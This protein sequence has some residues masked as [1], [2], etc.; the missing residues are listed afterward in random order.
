MATAPNRTFTTDLELKKLKPENKHYWM[1][2][3]ISPSLFLEVSPKGTKTWQYRYSVNGK[4]ERVKL[5][6]YPAM[7]LNQARIERARYE[8][9]YVSKGISKAEVKKQ[10]EKQ[11]EAKITF[12]DFA[13]KFAE[14][15]IT[16]TIKNHKT[17]MA[18]LNNDI[19]PFIGDKFL[20]EIKADHIDQIINRKLN[21]G[22]PAAAHQIR[23]LLRRIFEIAVDW[24]YIERTPVKKSILTQTLLGKPKQ[25]ALTTDEISVFYSQLFQQNIARATKLGLLLSLLVLVRKTELTTAKWEHINFETGIW[26][27]PTPKGSGQARNASEPFDIYMSS[28][29]KSILKELKELAGDSFYILPG[30]IPAKPISRTVFNTALNAVLRKMEGFGHFT[31]H[32][33]RRTAASRLNDL[34]YESDIIEKCLNHK[35]LGIRGIY[36]KAIY[37]DQRRNMMQ[38]WSNFVFEL[39]PLL[40]HLI[41]LNDQ[42]ININC[43]DTTRDN[44]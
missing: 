23:Q 41:E 19:F 16:G 11:D 26:H 36:N 25:R 38:E 17:M 5:G 7:S 37:E 28:Q 30:R 39:V 20:E 34:G 9:D 14:R 4:Q 33:L 32:D 22:F 12:H 13:L 27:I 40:N 10:K 44:Q 42:E 6:K 2:D 43:P 29:V 1:K 15:Y 18:Y 8:E 31:V 24:E 21:Q 35:M 3:I